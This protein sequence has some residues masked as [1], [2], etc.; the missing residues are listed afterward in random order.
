MAGS[1][2]TSSDVHPSFTSKVRILQPSR[3]EGPTARFSHQN[4]TKSSQPLHLLLAACDIVLPMLCSPNAAS[5][6]VDAAFYAGV[7]VIPPP[8]G[9]ACDAS[10]S[11]VIAHGAIEWVP[12]PASGAG[13]LH[14]SGIVRGLIAETST[15]PVAG[16]LPPRLVRAKLRASSLAYWAGGR[17]MQLA[18]EVALERTLRLAVDVRHCNQ[19]AFRIVPSSAFDC[20]KVPV[21]RGGGSLNM[22]ASA[23]CLM[24]QGDA[25]QVRGLDSKQVGAPQR[26]P[27]FV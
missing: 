24:T 27:P 1:S 17:Y 16:L 7:P 2:P 12:S 6:I 11:A 5:V 19:Q 15:W 14:Y 13:K 21:L 4:G 9:M 20:R 25:L 3:T 26:S 8:A 10:R 23:L 18:F 22:C